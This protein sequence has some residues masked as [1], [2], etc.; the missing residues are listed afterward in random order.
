MSKAPDE[1][2]LRT[3]AAIALRWPVLDVDC[4]PLVDLGLVQREGG[5]WVL[6]DKGEV[7]LLAATAALRGLKSWP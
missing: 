2:Q 4:L 7:T 6:T 3:M 5:E 1:Q